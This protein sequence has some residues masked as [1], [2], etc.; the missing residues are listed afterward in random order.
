MDDNAIQQKRSNNKDYRLVFR[1]IDID[2]IENCEI[3]WILEEKM[4]ISKNSN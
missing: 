2:Q 3:F 4:R 1:Y